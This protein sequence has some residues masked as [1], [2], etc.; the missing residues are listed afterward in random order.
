[1]S[2]THDTRTIAAGHQRRCTPCRRSLT[3]RSRD[4][5]RHGSSLASSWS[6][7]TI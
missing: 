3:T 4:G 1:M 5:G 7:D 6:A 2:A